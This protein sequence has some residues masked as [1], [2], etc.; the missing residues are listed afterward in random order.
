MVKIIVLI[1]VL[2]VP[3][4]SWIANIVKLT[5]CQFDSL[6]AEIVLRVIGIFMVPIGIVLGFIPH[7]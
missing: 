2:L 4:I 1:A 6:T 3:F 7:F 5:G